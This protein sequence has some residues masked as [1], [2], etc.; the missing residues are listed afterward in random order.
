MKK[1]KRIKWTQD[2]SWYAD[3]LWYF[4]DEAKSI[5]TGKSINEIQ[6]RRYSKKLE[7]SCCIPK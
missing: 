1:D 5:I 7:K 2:Q 6:Q 3:N 4:T